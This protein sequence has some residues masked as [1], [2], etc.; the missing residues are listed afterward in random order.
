MLHPQVTMGFYNGQVT[1]QHFMTFKT[2]IATINHRPNVMLC[3]PCTSHRI[4]GLGWLVWGFV[5]C[6]PGGIFVLPF[7]VH[8]KFSDYHWLLVG[9][10]WNM[11]F[12]FPYIGN[13]HS[14]WLIFFRGVQTTTQISW[15]SLTS[16]SERMNMHQLEIR[17]FTY[18]PY[19][20]KWCNM[21]ETN[22]EIPLVF[23]LVSRDHMGT[24][25]SIPQA[26]IWLYV[27]W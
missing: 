19:F 25:W 16:S 3:P 15:Y 26:S 5:P 4:V 21:G 11:T 22:A 23:W 17:S 2:S 6:H 10:D 13:N 24:S 27:S 14:N 12:I 18:R 9:G 8:A 20:M 1:A 7:L